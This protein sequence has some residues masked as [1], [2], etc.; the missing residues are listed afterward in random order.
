MPLINAVQCFGEVLKSAIEE[1]Y[2]DMF[3]ELFDKAEDSD[4]FFIGMKSE[5]ENPHTAETE[6]YKSF[7]LGRAAKT[8][9]GHIANT[10]NDSLNSLVEK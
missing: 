8:L 9:C 7:N 10:V 5:I 1:A 4:A 6:A 2:G 3:Q